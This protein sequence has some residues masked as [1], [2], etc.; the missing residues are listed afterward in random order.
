MYRSPEN[1]GPLTWPWPIL[2]M[3]YSMTHI[4]DPVKNTAS[5]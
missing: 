3:R 5:K 2:S 4:E 1:G